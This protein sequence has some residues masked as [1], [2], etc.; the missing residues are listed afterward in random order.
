MIKYIVGVDEVGRGPVAGPVAVG[1]VAISSDFDKDFFLGIRDSKK[2]SEK[3]RVEWLDKAGEA[4]L[5][6]KI[7]F[8]VSMMG[9]SVIDEKGIS[10]ALRKAVD[11]SLSALNLSPQECQVL[12]D[13]GLKAPSEFPFQKSLTKGDES[14]PVIS[15]ASIIA[16]VKRDRVMTEAGEKYQ[17]YRFEKNKGYGTAEHL[18]ALEEHGLCIIHRRSFLSKLGLGSRG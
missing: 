4:K 17:E 10:F 1:A 18:K 16:K 8:S 15:L 5:A 11:E 7:N 6:G 9:N 3:K 13:G 2:L 12:L 14:E